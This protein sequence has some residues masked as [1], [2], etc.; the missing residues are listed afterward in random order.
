[1]DSDENRSWVEGKTTR[2][3]SFRLVMT[4]VMVKGFARRGVESL[5]H[6]PGLHHLVYSRSCCQGLS[7]L[8]LDRHVGDRG[9]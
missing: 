2:D 8:R 9:E 7:G 3:K 6:G 4:W 5:S 1:M